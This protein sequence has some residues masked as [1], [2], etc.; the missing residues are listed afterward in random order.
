MRKITFFLSALLAFA[1]ATTAGAQIYVPTERV[2]ALENGGTYMLYNT[3]FNGDQ[4]RTGFLSNNGSSLGHSGSAAGLSKNFAGRSNFLWK[5]ETTNTPYL[6]YM[7][8]VSSET[9]VG[10][11]G[12][13]NNTDKRDL[14]IQPWGSSQAPKAGVGSEKADGTV[15]S[16]SED[17][18]YD[19]VFTICGT[20]VQSNQQAN[21]NGDCWNGNVGG[22]SKWGSS[23]PYAFYKYRMA[24]TAEQID[25][26]DAAKTTAENAVWSLQNVYGLVTDASKY[27][28]NATQPG[29]GSIDN[30]LDGV[31]D[32]NSYFHTKWGSV[33]GDYHY[34]QAELPDMATDI[35]IFFKK[36]SDNNNNRPT[37]ILVKGSNDGETFSDV[38]TLTAAQDGLPTEA[39][40]IGYGSGNIHSDTP[41]KY[42]RFVVK[43]T[44]SGALDNQFYED[45]KPQ[46]H[47]FF[48]FSEF[49][50]LPGG[51]NKVIADILAAYNAIY[52]LAPT[53]KA[54]A[55]N[56][57]QLAGVVE[58]V[59]NAYAELD[60]LTRTVTIEHLFDG[61]LA[62]TT[63]TEGLLGKN[64]TIAPEFSRYGLTCNDTEKTVLVGENTKVT[65]NYTWNTT[66]KPFET[67]TVANSDFN[68]ADSHVNWYYLTQRNKYSRYDATDNKIKSGSTERDYLLYK[69]LFAFEGN[70]ITGYKIYNYA[71]GAN[72]VLGGPVSNNAHVTMMEDAEGTERFVLEN[73]ED[74][75]GAFHLVFRKDNTTDGYLND[76]T[77][78]IGYWT[79]A[80]LARVDG[81]STFVF[82]PVSDDAFNKIPDNET[83]S[84]AKDAFEAALA[85][86]KTYSNHIG[87][88][89]NQYSQQSD[90]TN[91]ATAVTDAEAFKSAFNAET[92]TAE[93][94]NEW[95]GKLT[96]LVEH[97]TFNMPT[98]KSFIRIRC[99]NG[100][101][102]L[103]SETHT[104][105][106]NKNGRLKLANTVEPNSIFYYDN[107]RL[108]AYQTGLYVNEMVYAPVGGNGA[109]VELTDGKQIQMGTYILKCGTRYLYGADDVLD[110][111]SGVDNRNGYTWWLEA[112]N[113]LPVSIGD[114]KFATLWTP[115]ALNVPEYVT[116][117]TATINGDVLELEE[118][119]G[120]IPAETG[121]VINGEEGS[122][123]FNIAP[124]TPES[125]E[126]G[127]LT[128]TVNTITTPTNT[129]TLQEVSDAVVGFK[130]YNGETV[131]GFKAR[132]ETDGTQHTLRMVFG[133][134]ATGIDGVAAADGQNAGA[135]YDMSGRRVAKPAKGLYIVNGQ[136]VLF[137]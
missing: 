36:R 113:A 32:N 18:V 3:A 75:D 133:G 60:K 124:E 35:R 90:D 83:K 43:T 13:T 136:K 54:F 55:D 86:A 53:D 42:Y 27:T 128:G 57:E 68:D 45:P 14:Y 98:A 44:N 127:S 23:H 132:L 108:L 10:P 126:K 89:Y 58:Q 74:E 46:G 50:V 79:A 63:T 38:T 29:E 52:T 100:N 87:T 17:A 135:I 78:A 9:Y 69:D 41:Y 101:R 109:A 104:S 131:S 125:I 103:L 37:E 76:V 59:N 31:Y 65:F 25:L 77:G 15:I 110:S 96:T 99:A 62:A 73:N 28:S 2:E 114:S 102:R 6:Y 51:E 107:N 20:G 67:S 22:W 16:Y 122:Y 26:L 4:C 11:A 12:V 34:L 121:V 88:G 91:F 80:S 71:A 120:V 70:P 95:A 19:N 39:G 137:K 81:G 111:G 30:L 118:V 119:K 5:I 48:T 1:G 97:L 84:V 56:V 129:L 7:Q 94:M 49:Y 72:K 92:T 47:P 61:E 33:V 115:V 105:T 66:E 123:N 93:E 24:V 116:A 130:M 82:V 134:T 64:I 112:V 106:D 85:I 40:I 117:Y 21:G 8:S